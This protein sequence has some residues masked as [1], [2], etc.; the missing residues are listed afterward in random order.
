MKKVISIL[1]ILFLFSSF[2]YAGGGKVQERN[3]GLYEDILPQMM[4]QLDVHGEV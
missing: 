4:R 3:L 1:L 2:V